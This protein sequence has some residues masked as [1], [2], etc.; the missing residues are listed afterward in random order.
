M[1]GKLGEALPDTGFWR[2]KRVFLTGHTGFKGAWL[3]LWLQRLGANVTGFALEPERPS[4]AQDA[5]VERAIVSVRGDIRDLPALRRA[6]GEADPQIILHLAAQSLVRRS[7]RQPLE[8]FGVNVM[9]T[10]HVLEAAA[11]RAPAVVCVTSDKCYLNHGEARAFKETDALGGHDPYSASKAA[12]ELVAGAWPKTPNLAVATA[13]AGNVV[14]GGDWAEDRLVP[15]CMRAFAAG[16]SVGIRNPLAVRP[17][18]HV[19]DPLCGYLLLAERL[20][21]G[22]Q[23]FARPWNFGPAAPERQPVSYVAERLAR[24]WGGGAWHVAK[25]E[26][27]HEAATLAVDA[28][29]A[30]AEL[31]WQPRLDLGTALDWTGQF[32]RRLAEGNDAAHLVRA[33]IERYESLCQ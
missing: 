23:A 12:A 24:A 11:S 17:W 31:G 28:S 8:T 7:Y 5:G 2:G 14:G 13:R 4:L 32:Y 21:A 19:L 1:A 6:I 29:L 30:R 25:G 9:G 15:D 33:D 20:Y 3:A 16:E 10:A 22:G 26:H 18:Q 27:P